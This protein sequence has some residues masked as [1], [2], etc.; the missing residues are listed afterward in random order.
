LFSYVKDNVQPSC[1]QKKYSSLPLQQL[2]KA[3]D[4]T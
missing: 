2:I 3:L 1:F 4:V